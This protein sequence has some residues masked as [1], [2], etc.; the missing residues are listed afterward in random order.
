LVEKIQI[1][2]LGALVNNR[3][4]LYYNCN[5]NGNAFIQFHR[6]THQT[7]N[8]KDRQQLM[9]PQKQSSAK[10]ASIIAMTA[11]LYAVFFLVSYSIAV[12]GFALLYLP[13]ILL[14]VFP[15]W[16]GWSGL[17]GAMIGA[18]IGGAFIEQLGFLGVFESVVALLIYMINWAL[19]PK[20]AGEDGNKRNFLSLFVVYTLSLFVGTSYIIWQYTIVPHLFS[21]AQVPIILLSTF[22][23]NLPIVLVTCPALIR[24]ISPKL[25]TWGMYSG[26]FAEWRSLRAKSQTKQP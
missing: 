13:I 26:S 5:T 22:A 16:F 6:S 3:S 11:A 12:P 19:I 9:I 1:P 21:A 23:L 7:P 4:I 17:A 20:K 18:F 8:I 10:R 24:A 25:R 14:G 15:L 2:W